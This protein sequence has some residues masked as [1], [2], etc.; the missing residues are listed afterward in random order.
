VTAIGH[1]IPVILI[2][3]LR[4]GRA[5][6]ARL[7]L[8]SLR[9]GSRRLDSFKDAGQDEAV[10][11][12]LGGEVVAARQALE[13]DD[14]VDADAV[15]EGDDARQHLHLELDDQERRVLDVD[16]DDARLDVRA[17]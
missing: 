5:A 1:S 10:F 3:I 6:Q 2:A 8:G 17:G 9:R 14:A 12:L 7:T 4:G 16:A 15:D 13:A 11:E